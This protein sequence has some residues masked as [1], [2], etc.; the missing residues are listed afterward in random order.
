[1]A[2]PIADE[3]LQR[4]I[5][6][7]FQCARCGFCCKGDGI[8]RLG[9]LEVERM[10]LALGQTRHRF[11]KTYA[12]RI[13][14]VTWILKDRWARPRGVL[15]GSPE[16]WCI[17]LDQAADGAYLCHL[18]EAKPDQCRRFPAQWI[19]DDSLSTCVGLRT[20]VTALRRAAA[21]KD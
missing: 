12:L 17:F 18:E 10:A 8:V 5:D 3:A 7:R 2:T 14:R 9:R 13:D 11:L 19:N 16:K 20:L 1:M 21:D 15:E 4:A 6:E